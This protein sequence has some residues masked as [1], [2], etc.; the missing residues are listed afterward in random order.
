MLKLLLTFDVANGVALS[1]H[2]ALPPAQT[3]LDWS[4]ADVESRP[5][6][7]KWIVAESGLEARWTVRPEEPA[8]FVVRNGRLVP[9]TPYNPLHG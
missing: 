6:Q 5:L 2:N 7:M 3:E 8:L 4:P 9:A 1:G